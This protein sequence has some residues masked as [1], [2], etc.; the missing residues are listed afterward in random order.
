MSLFKQ[1][2]VQVDEGLKPMDAGAAVMIKQAWIKAVHARGIKG[3]GA[4]WVDIMFKEGLNGIVGMC[5]I[6]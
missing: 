4:Q 5:K 2:D 6:S 1:Q 3:I